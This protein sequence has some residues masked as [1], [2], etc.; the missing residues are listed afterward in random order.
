MYITTL[1]QMSFHDRGFNSRNGVDSQSSR[2]PVRSYDRGIDGRR[3][4]GALPGP[5]LERA[6]IGDLLQC[7]KR[8]TT[9]SKETYWR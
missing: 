7:Q 4:G 1:S 3:R 8:P 6:D 9:V 5:I 2:V